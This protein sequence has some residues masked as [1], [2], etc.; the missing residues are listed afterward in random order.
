MSLD[1]AEEGVACDIVVFD[2]FRQAV[3]DRKTGI[4]TDRPP[5]APAEKVE[6]ILADLKILLV[7]DDAIIGRDIADIL[8]LHG[9]VVVGPC[10]T[11]ATALQALDEKP[12]A[13][14]LDVNLGRETSADVAIRLSEMNVPHLVLSGQID[15]HDLGPAFANAAIMQKPFRERDLVAALSHLWSTSNKQDA[16]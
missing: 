16:P 3:S 15:S 10:T 12:D 6:A 4:S 11:R 2:S 8:E 1:Y 9:A 13:A 7:E 5:A 14:L